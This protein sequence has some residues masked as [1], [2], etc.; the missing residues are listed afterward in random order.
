M[1]I[2][3]ARKLSLRPLQRFAACAEA[4]PDLPKEFFV[5]AGQK[6]FFFA[7]LF[8]ACHNAAIRKTPAALQRP[9]AG[10]PLNWSE[11]TSDF[12]GPCVAF[13]V[14][15]GQPLYVVSCLSLPTN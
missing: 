5:P 7:S 6:R 10:N 2:T 8:A 11:S 4:V 3:A 14:A 1:Q 9:G 12:T 13:Q 15:S